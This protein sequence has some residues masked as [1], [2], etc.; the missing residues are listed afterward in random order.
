[1]TSAVQAGLFY[2]N[3]AGIPAFRWYNKDTGKMFVSNHPADARFL[4]RRPAT[5][6]AQSGGA[7][8]RTG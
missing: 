8:S 6:V 3:N 7:S 1:M 2:G 5:E 4:D